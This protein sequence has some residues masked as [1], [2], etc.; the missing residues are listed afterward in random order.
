M[1]FFLRIS[2]SHCYCGVKSVLNDTMKIGIVFGCEDLVAVVMGV[3]VIPFE[4]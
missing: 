4:P 2:K 3:M 1:F